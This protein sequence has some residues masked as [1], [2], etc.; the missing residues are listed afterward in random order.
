[1]KNQTYKYHLLIRSFIAL[2]ILKKGIFF[3]GTATTA[4]FFGFLAILASLFLTSNTP[5]PRNSTLS[6]LLKAKLRV[7]KNTLII[8]LHLFDTIQY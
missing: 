3:D 2:P 7:L 4:P 6:F 5:K 8:Y 1:M